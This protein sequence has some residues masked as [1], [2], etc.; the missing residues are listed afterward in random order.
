MHEECEWASVQFKTDGGQINSIFLFCVRKKD[1]NAKLRTHTDNGQKWMRSAEMK[2]K[3][4]KKKHVNC[5]L[6]LFL[7]VLL[8]AQKS[9]SS[10]SCFQ[11]LNGVNAIRIISVNICVCV[12]GATFLSLSSALPLNAF[13]ACSCFSLLLSLGIAFQSICI[14]GKLFCKENSFLHPSFLPLDIRP[15]FSFSI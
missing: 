9:A 1:L 8:R 14:A 11:Y 2:T 5:Y 13:Y 12:R 4:E 7:L 6:F 10:V 3:D 15:T